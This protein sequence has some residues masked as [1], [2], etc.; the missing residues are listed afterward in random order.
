MFADESVW[1]K[2]AAAR[3]AAAKAFETAR[4]S[5]STDAVVDAALRRAEALA[6]ESNASGDSA[7]AKKALADGVSAAGE[8]LSVD[9]LRRL[10]DK[11]L[12][13]AK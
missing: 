3:E 4:R 9:A 13:P 10:M 7:A 6:P 5:G 11:Q 2:E 12:K 8:D 1:R